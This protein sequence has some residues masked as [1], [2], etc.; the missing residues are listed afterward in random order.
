MWEDPWTTKPGQLGAYAPHL[1]AFWAK[2]CTSAG[3]PLL[4][5]ND[6]ANALHAIPAR[7]RPGRR[8]VITALD[9]ALG[10]PWLDNWHMAIR[11]RAAERHASDADDLP[12]KIGQTPADLGQQAEPRPAPGKT[13]IEAQP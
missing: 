5:W 10:K 12:A 9:K 3:E 13:D 1:G 7:D 2:Y 4:A 8:R 6:I 11:R